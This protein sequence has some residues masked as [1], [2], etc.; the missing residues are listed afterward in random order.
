MPLLIGNPTQTVRR[1]MTMREVIRTCESRRRMNANSLTLSELDPLYI[2]T[3]SAGLR[4][5]AL[6]NSFIEGI[7]PHFMQQQHSSA[8]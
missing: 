7:I 1:L 5:T 8:S 2:E 4:T 6:R 3:S